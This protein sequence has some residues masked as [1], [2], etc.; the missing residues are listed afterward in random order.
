MTTGSHMGTVRHVSNHTPI[1]VTEAAKRLRMTRRG[2]HK[3]IHRGDLPA[4]KLPGRT[5]A[6][7]LDPTEVDRFANSRLSA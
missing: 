4:L 2:V 3:A 5:G 7:V 1:G 6:Y